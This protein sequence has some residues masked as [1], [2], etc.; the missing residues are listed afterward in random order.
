MAAA[1]SQEI[2][3]LVAAVSAAEERIASMD[4]SLAD[5]REKAR[6]EQER[7]RSS[8]ALL[9]R[10][11]QQLRENRGHLTK[12]ID[13]EILR[14]YERI[15]SRMGGIAFVASSRERCSACKMQIPHQLYVRLMR[16]NEILTCEHCGRLQ[17][18]AGHFPEKSAHDDSDSEEPEDDET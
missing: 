10:R 9:K 6:E 7:L 3:K 4:A 5:L 12:Q 8:E 13:E 14:L 17:Y 11:I 18:W 16:G 2:Q 1:R 15:R